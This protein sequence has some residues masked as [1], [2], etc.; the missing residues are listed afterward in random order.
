MDNQSVSHNTPTKPLGYN[1]TPLT[2][3]FILDAQE[4]HEKQTRINFPI[5]FE[6]I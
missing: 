3:T 2:Q 4:G 1:S 6:D 5:K